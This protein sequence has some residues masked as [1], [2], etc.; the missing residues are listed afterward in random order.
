M[1]YGSDVIG[2]NMDGNT[3]LDSVLQM[4]RPGFLST[5]V[6]E[7]I[8][9]EYNFLFF[10]FLHISEIQDLRVLIRLFQKVFPILIT[11]CLHI[12]MIL[13][14]KFHISILQPN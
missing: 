5:G 8:I 13:N 4:L 9:T 11:S 3:F 1:E 6:K 2:K 14:F 10:I 7:S 12:L